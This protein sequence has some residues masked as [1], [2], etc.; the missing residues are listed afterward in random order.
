MRDARARV[1]DAARA[2]GLP[3]WLTLDACRRAGLTEIADS[4]LTEEQEMALS[5]H[6]TPNA[7]CRYVK[8]TEVQRLVAARKRRAWLGEQE[9]KTGDNSECEGHS[10][11]GMKTT[12]AS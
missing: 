11:L 3:D 8:R 6:T 5:G 4:G 12:S 2:A 1:R 10:K 9:Q 7:K